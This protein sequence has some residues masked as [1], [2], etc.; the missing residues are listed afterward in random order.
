MT[1]VCVRNYWTQLGWGIC[2]FSVGVTAGRE[3]RGCCLS[4]L[5]VVCDMDACMPF[6]RVCDRLTMRCTAVKD[7]CYNM[8]VEE[9]S[10]GLGGFDHGHEK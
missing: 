10:G 1:F 2:A 3:R 9:G 5:S 7:R 6:C 8:V 4:C